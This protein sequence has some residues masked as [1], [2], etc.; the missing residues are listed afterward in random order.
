MCEHWIFD[1]SGYGFCLYGQVLVSCEGEED[2][3]DP[4]VEELKDASVAEQIDEM[5][6]RYED[7]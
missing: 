5:E 3:C 2:N 7:R 6:Y 1:S 4:E